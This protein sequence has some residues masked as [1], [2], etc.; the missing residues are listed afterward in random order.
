MPRKSTPLVTIAQV[1]I[2]MKSDKELVD[3]MYSGFQKA[4]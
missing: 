4:Y 2:G 1:C 3:E